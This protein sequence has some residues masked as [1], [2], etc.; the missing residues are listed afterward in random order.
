MMIK[1]SYFYVVYKAKQKEAFIF[2]WG[3]R[4]YTGYPTNYSAIYI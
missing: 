3:D 1:Y 2:A 4:T